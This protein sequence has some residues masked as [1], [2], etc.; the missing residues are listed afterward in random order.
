MTL[1]LVI[2]IACQ[3]PCFLNFLIWFLLFVRFIDLFCT[4]FPVSLNNFAPQEVCFCDV[5]GGCEVVDCILWST[6]CHF[7]THD[8]V[9][10]VFFVKNFY[11]RHRVEL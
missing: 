5:G 4:L 3:L 6:F 2:V 1:L 9:F 7:V 8:A 10:T 11:K